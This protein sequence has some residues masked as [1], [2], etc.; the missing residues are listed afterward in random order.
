MLGD[1]RE[2]HAD[3]VNLVAISIS[4]KDRDDTH[5]VSSDSSEERQPGQDVQLGLRRLKRDEL[6]AQPL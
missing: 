6:A 5:G 1:L 4:H 2:I 3:L